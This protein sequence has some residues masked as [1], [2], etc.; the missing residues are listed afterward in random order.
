M[1]DASGNF[2]AQARTVVI[3]EPFAVLLLAVVEHVSSLNC[4]LG[5]I[6]PHRIRNPSATSV[7]SRFAGVALL[8]LS[9]LDHYFL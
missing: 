7:I 6:G 4:S 8:D 1:S 3:F 5:L 9:A 2:T